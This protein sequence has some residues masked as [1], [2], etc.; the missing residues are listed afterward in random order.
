MDFL[1]LLT[2]F[3]AK[4][5]CLLLAFLLII[6]FSS[7]VFSNHFT[8]SKIASLSKPWG[9]S[10]I[11]EEQVIVTERT[12]KI[13]LIDLK[14]GDVSEVAHNL[15]YKTIGQ[16]GLLDIIFKDGYVWVSYTQKIGILRYGTSVAKGKFNQKKINFINIFQQNSA[17]SSGQHFGGRLLIEGEHLFLTLGER[18]LG[19]VA[20]DPTRHPGSIIRINLDGSIPSDNPHFLSK[21]NWGPAVFQIGVRNP[22][23]ITKSPNGRQILISNHGAKG[24][25]WIGEIEKGGNFGWN[26]LGWGGVNYNGSHIG[27]KWKEG[28]SKPLK[29]WT[30]SI[31]V[32]ALAVY[33]GSE[34]MEW[35][36]NILVASLKDKSL[37]LLKNLNSNNILEEII[38]VGLIDRIRDIEI[39]KNTGKI[40]LL[41]EKYFSETGPEED[42]LWIL[43]KN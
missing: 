20:Q 31:G 3:S 34:F 43:E 37:R 21:S 11:G 25:D 17:N 10:F 1:K 41:S 28:F 15:P 14:N 29:Y 42:G 30:P 35:N 22:Q 13:K 36:D 6:C 19:R 38:F 33:S 39:E 32:S 18:S 7:S 8:L 23:G 27:P 24:G 16:G 2:Y 12:G 26:V 4:S 5:K 9:M 40:F